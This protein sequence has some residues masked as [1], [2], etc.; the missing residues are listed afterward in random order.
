[1]VFQT[2]PECYRIVINETAL[3]AVEVLYDLKA[4]GELISM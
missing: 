4:P 3:L 1:M 2:A